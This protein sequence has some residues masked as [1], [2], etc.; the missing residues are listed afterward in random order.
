[1]LAIQ[2]ARRD[3]IQRGEA[4]NALYLLEHTPTITLGRNT[5][6]EHLLLTPEKYAE[7]GITVIK[8]DRGGD[9]TYHGPGQLVAYP[10]LNLNEWNTSVGWYLRNLEQC[11][12]D[13]LASYD[14]QGERIE[15]HTGVWVGGAKIA[16]IGVGIH[17]WVSY[18]GIALNIAPDMSHFGHIIPCGIADKPVCSLGQLLDRVP[19]MEEVKEKFSAAFMNTFEV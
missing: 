15:E 3:A 11:L 8:A 10:I 2:Y 13:L 19:D 16:A 18:H 1:M 6:P 14:I 4:A 17:H 9:V 7:K 12:I 5:K